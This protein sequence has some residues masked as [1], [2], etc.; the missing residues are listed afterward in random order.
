MINTDFWSSQFNK[1]YQEYTHTH[2]YK[3]FENCMMCLIFTNGSCKRYAWEF[4]I[5]LEA[6]RV[7]HGWVTSL[8]LLTFMHWRRK[9]QPPPVFLPGESRDGGAWWAAVYGVAQS[10]TRL[11]RL[12]SSSRRHEGNLKGNVPIKIDRAKALNREGPSWH[13]YEKQECPVWLKYGEW[14]ENLREIRLKK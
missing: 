10:R 2:I 1:W 12:S 5:S 8:S 7:G 6:W 9:W 13:V 3:F 14:E 4:Y 11:K